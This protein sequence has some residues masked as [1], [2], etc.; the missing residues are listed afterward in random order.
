[1]SDDLRRGARRWAEPA[2]QWRTKVQR[3]VDAGIVSSE[4]GE[5]I[6]ALESI[7]TALPTQHDASGPALS[8]VVELSSYIGIVV[9]GL[10]TALFLGNSWHR[11]GVAGHASVALL[12]CV[13]GLVGAY[14]VAQFGDAGARRLSGFLRLIGTAGAATATGVLVGPD[15]VGHHGLSALFVGVVV[16]AL[17]AL[18][19]R[20]QDRPLQFLSTLLGAA[21]TLG[22]LDTVAHLHPTSSEVALFLWFAAVAVGLMSLQMLRPART[23]IVVAELGSFVGAVALSFPNHLGGVL[24]GIFTA[25]CAVG[26]GFVLERPLIVVIGAIG[27]FM[28][29]FRVFALY[30]HST[31]AALGAFILGLALIFVALVAARHASTHE[32]RPVE[33]TSEAPVHVEWYEPW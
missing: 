5:E 1:M 13:A 14:A 31:N 28:F 12:F 25:L 23:G 32:R 24:L 26:I 11:L 17:S 7:E 30:L 33:T 3:W 16:L 20:N 22:A 21:V 29:D 6:L 18:L 9:V 15:A 8:R 2:D 4:Q 10:G 27:F 19:W